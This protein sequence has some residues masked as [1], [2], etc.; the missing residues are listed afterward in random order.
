M[1][2]FEGIYNLLVVPGN[3]MYDSVHSLKMSVVSGWYVQIKHVTVNQHIL[4]SGLVNDSNLERIKE[5][6]EN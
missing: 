6:W 4:F 2:K 3:S 1:G 5:K